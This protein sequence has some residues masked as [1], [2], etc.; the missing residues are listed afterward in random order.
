[1]DLDDIWVSPFG[2]KAWES[3]TSTPFAKWVMKG[4]TMKL[5][6][7]TEQAIHMIFIVDRLYN[8]KKRP[9]TI[10]DV[11][12]YITANKT[13]ASK[14]LETMA[15]R[16]I[17]SSRRGRGGGY[18]MERDLKDIRI[19]DI[20]ECFEEEV[21]I[22]KKGDTPVYLR[23]LRRHFNKCILDFYSQPLST[24]RGKKRKGV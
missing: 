5:R 10:E 15:R 1:M 14:I 16:G 11:L 9:Q 3:Q 20:A 22:G 18:F 4:R 23:K 8:K 17:L 6:K 7:M 24:L 21:L 12:I 2:R 19:G 13:V